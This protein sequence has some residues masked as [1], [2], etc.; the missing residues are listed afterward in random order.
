MNVLW[1]INTSLPE[2]SLLLK[3]NPSFFGGWLINASK[4]LSIQPGISLSIAFPK[5]GIDSYIELKGERINYY[6]FKPIKLDDHK[7]IED[8]LIFKQLID[9]VKPDIV[10]VF[11]TEFPHS[12]SMINCTNKLNIYSVL[13]I[14]GL[15]SIY[16]KHYYAS[17]PARVVYGNTIR[18]LLRRDSIH[19]QMRSFKSRGKFEIESILRSKHIIGRT[20][21]DL[22]CTSQINPNSNY[23]FCNETLREE[24]YKYQ[25][26]IDQCEPH[27]IFLSQGHYP[28]KG[29]HYVLEAMP[30]ILE[31]Y[32]DTKLYI[33]G[34]NITKNDTLKSKIGMSYYGKYLKKLIKENKLEN[35][36]F[37]TGP[38][39]EEAMCKRYLDSHLF[40]S[41]ASI[42]NSPNSLGEAM[43]LG[44]PSISSNVGGAMDMMRDKEEGFIYQT[45]APYMMAFYVTQ[46]FSDNELAVKVSQNARAHA[47]ITHNRNT[48]TK[49]LLEI[50]SNITL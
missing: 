40:I 27:S 11:G 33:G 34:V 22:A 31:K 16:S 46:L 23:H 48:N 49:R 18:N 24:F 37:F 3:E 28:I 15:V 7:I 2:A 47:Q 29:L 4:D 38:L 9:I 20:T 17:L 10:H 30:L 32:P 12:L 1:L 50:Y 6:P 42:E 19:N 26:S 43:L 39:D 8:N 13:S 44:V 35:S 14:Q 5:D 21:W 45:D 41:P 36:V 25:W